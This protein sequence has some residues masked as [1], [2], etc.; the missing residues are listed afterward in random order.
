MHT[1]CTKDTPWNYRRSISEKG[2][3]VA[4]WLK[5]WA[6]D[7]EV[8]GSSP[9]AAMIPLLDPCGPSSFTPQVLRYNQDGNPT[10]WVPVTVPITDRYPQ[11]GE[12]PSPDGTWTDTIP[13]LY[14]REPCTHIHTLSDNHIVMS[15]IIFA[16]FQCSCR[17]SLP[18]GTWSHLFRSRNHYE[19]RSFAVQSITCWKE[20]IEHGEK[21]RTFLEDMRNFT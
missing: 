5:W 3:G 21:H 14:L 4:W 17:L 16:I 7:Q 12:Y 20:T 8:R 11:G 18:P 13:F 9:D 6:A 2:A 1:Q 15:S 10:L 19:Q